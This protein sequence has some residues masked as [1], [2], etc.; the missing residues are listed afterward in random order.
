MKAKAD[1]VEEFKLQVI[2][3]KEQNKKIMSERSE[4]EE[5]TI[6][7][8]QQLRKELEN[9]KVEVIAKDWS[10]ENLLAWVDELEIKNTVMK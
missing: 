10:N 8:V 3:L 7:M 9:L 1:K 5:E 4:T 2:D 6:S